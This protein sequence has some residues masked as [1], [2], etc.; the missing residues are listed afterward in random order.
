[1]IWK[2][3]QPRCSAECHIDF[4]GKG[5]V[6]SFEMGIFETGR[7]RVFAGYFVRVRGP[8][9]EGWM[10]ESALSMR[11]ALRAL[12][13]EIAGNGGRLLCVGLDPRFR[14]S[15]LSVDTGYGYI[16]DY[17]SAIHMMEHPSLFA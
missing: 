11:K 10:G 15:G 16:D 5:S 13:D 2:K 9:G 1:M 12:D 14:E 3:Y 17:P 6:V 8:D 7:S 4:N